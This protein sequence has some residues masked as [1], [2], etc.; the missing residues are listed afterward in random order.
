MNVVIEKRENLAN[1]EEAK[2]LLSY[3]QNH[4]ELIFKQNVTFQPV[5]IKFSDCLV[6]LLE[7]SNESSDCCGNFTT[8]DNKFK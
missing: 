2:K 6:F 8:E 4:K 7:I 1:V 3:L 5:L